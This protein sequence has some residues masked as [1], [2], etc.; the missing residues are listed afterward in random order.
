MLNYYEET[1][2]LVTDEDEYKKYLIDES[3]PLFD[4]L[5]LIIKKGY[6]IQRQALLNNLNIYINEP[7]FKSLIQY[8]ISE[9]ETWDIETSLLFPKCL[10][11]ILINHL[12]SINNE[13]FNI[14]LKH[15]ILTISSG[16]EKISEEYVI[17]FDIII[18]KYT[19]LF[20]N[21]K[22][23]P[24]QINDDIFE[25]IVSLGKLGENKDNKRLCCYLS[26]C[27][28]RLI[29]HMEENEKVQ[30]MFNRICLL[31]GELEK[32]TER[33][34]SRELRY[35]IPIFKDKICEKNDIIKAIKSYINHY[36]DHA[37]QTTTVVSLLI[38][39]K[40]I[41]Q[42]IKDLIFDKIREILDDNNYEEDH[43][44][45][46]V[47]TFINMIY[48]LCLE[49]EQKN[50]NRKNNNYDYYELNDLI[51]NTLNMKF[52]NNLLFKNKIEPLII[53]NFDK[54]SFILKHSS[55][56]NDNNDNLQI[57][58]LTNFNCEEGVNIENIFFR[59]FNR[60][61]QKYNNY[62]ISDEEYSPDINK[63]SNE[64][65]S[66][67]LLLNLDKMLSCL[68]NLKYAKYLFEKISNLFKK[69]TITLLKIY[70]CELTSNNCSKNSNY[71]YRLLL[72]ILEKGY[73]NINSIHSQANKSIPMNNS[74][75]GNSINSNISL[76]NDNN[77]Y[78]KLFQN[79]LVNILFLLNTMNESIE[80]QIHLLIAKTFQ[81]IIKLIYK[82]YK[83]FSQNA[84][85][86]FNI[87]KIYDD[88]YNGMF[89]IIK[90][91]ESGNQIKIEYLNVIPYLI[92]YGKNRQSY[93]NF[94][95]DEIFKSSL[96]FRRRHS[97]DFIEKC[98]NLYSLKLFLKFNFM[99]IIYY[100]INDK[101]NI[102]STSILEKVLIFYKKIKL[103]SNS[104]IEKIFSILSEFEQ[105]NKDSDSIKDFDI[106]KNKIIKKILELKN[107]KNN[108]SG[109][110][111][112]GE[113][114]EEYEIRRIKA[115]ETKK[116]KKEN[117][118]FGKT[119]QNLSLFT[120]V[121]SSNKNNNNN[122][123][124]TE[125]KIEFGKKNEKQILSRN[126][127]MKEFQL[128]QKEKFNREK[129][130]VEKSITGI[131]QNINNKISTKKYLP[132]L[133]TFKRKNSCNNNHPFKLNIFNNNI[134]V[135]NANQLINNSLNSS[136]IML[137]IKEK[138]P[139]KKNNLRS[140]NNRLCS[141][142]GNKIKE[143]ISI[144]INKSTNLKPEK[145]FLIKN[146]LK[147][148]LFIDDNNFQIINLSGLN[149]SSI[150]SKII[151]F[152]GKNIFKEMS[153][154]EKKNNYVN[155]DNKLNPCIK[156]L[157]F[158]LKNEIKGSKINKNSYYDNANRITIKAKMNEFNKTIK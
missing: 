156:K 132:K 25:I 61:F 96:F 91:D 27:M 77:Y 108:F 75:N 133:K 46:I 54:I 50:K 102:I 115:K 79:I 23:F 26:S 73:K 103:Y 99:E 69:D 66:K 15:F 94:V 142:S 11:N 7:L 68:N 97:I 92:L 31:F 4:K 29:G 81:K 32:N 109:I 87:D 125:K 45:I 47:E 80:F 43:K 147:N 118:I 95:E 3:L 63:N 18:E 48:E 158:F 6:P 51:N 35:L 113:L 1:M 65:L 149:K 116:I 141:A 14:I 36:W 150:V 153:C 10:H 34:I 64:N 138:T 24:F 12:S 114:E 78:F 117:H 38:N 52:M 120:T 56:Y 112:E 72:C 126:N 144:N 37:I 104:S 55:L 101:N 44:N 119:Y 136:K 8:I 122:I 59:I 5:N 127:D 70:A 128:T 60:V 89:H 93:Y 90:N 105:L 107:I 19:T 100:L 152:S 106:E 33:Q 148:K 134:I 157:T 9:I 143:S 131:L 151:K 71:L 139:E 130:L 49:Y 98:L 17:Y 145:I 155:K 74:S 83:P 42:E 20:N 67:L 2:P 28:C 129:L 154:N 124:K 111:E 121:N 13:L 57:S 76:L 41:N 58:Y 40:Y 85:D 86:K 22:T 146:Q 39:Y 82:Y 62:N 137:V 53:I 16:N 30:K 140:F 88:I 84:K 21:G 135:N 110:S 123:D